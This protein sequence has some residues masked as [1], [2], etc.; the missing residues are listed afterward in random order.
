MTIFVRVV[1][2]G[3][4]AAAA[5]EFRLTGTM[6]GHHIRALETLLGGRREDR[7][8]AGSRAA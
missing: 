1:E 3:S 6:V 7:R 8:R 4:F 2:R 5:E